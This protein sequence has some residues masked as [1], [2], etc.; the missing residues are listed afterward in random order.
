[1]FT[2][3]LTVFELTECHMIANYSDYNNVSEV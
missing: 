1:M 3:F 2:V